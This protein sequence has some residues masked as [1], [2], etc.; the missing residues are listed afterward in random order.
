[1]YTLS[2]LVV[3][4]CVGVLFASFSMVA[5]T[6]VASSNGSSDAM[7]AQFY[8]FATT[9]SKSIPALGWVMMESVPSLMRAIIV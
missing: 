7:I 6:Q 1:M 4:G 2:M 8:A 9:A 3:F 5:P